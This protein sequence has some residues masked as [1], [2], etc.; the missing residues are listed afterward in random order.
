MDKIRMLIA[1]PVVV[2]FVRYSFHDIIPIVKNAI[3]MLPIRKTRKEFLL[4]RI[5]TDLGIQ[6][7]PQH[8]ICDRRGGG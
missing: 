2:M 7:M 3:I 6:S 1:K 4:S 5:D 8:L